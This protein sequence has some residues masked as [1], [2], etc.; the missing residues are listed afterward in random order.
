MLYF[1]NLI[2]RQTSHLNNIIYRK[3]F[4]LHFCSYF[5]SFVSFSFY[6]S[7]LFCIIQRILHV[8]ISFKTGILH[9]NDKLLAFLILTIYIEYCFTIRMHIAHVLT[10]KECYVLNN[11]FTIKQ[12][13]EEINKQILVRVCA[14]D[15]LKTEVGQQTD[16]SFFCVSHN[17]II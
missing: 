6:N 10:I 13:I 2:S 11:L 3:A 5:Y 1:F 12:G 7:F 4:C 8:T 16:I 17:V 14:K 9:L 15:S